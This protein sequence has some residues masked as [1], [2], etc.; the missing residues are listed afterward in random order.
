MED[1]TPTE[2]VFFTDQALSGRRIARA[3]AVSASCRAEIHADN[4]AVDALDETWLPEVGKR[5]WIVVTKDRKIQLRR[6]EIEA[7][8]SA[9]VRAFIFLDG[10]LPSDV[11]IA[12]I[13]LLMPK[14]VE[15]IRNYPPPFVFGIETPDRLVQLYPPVI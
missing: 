15:T 13:E 9:K 4:F 12:L 10:Q 5:E 3:L 8:T 7:L 6:N 2:L 1:Y 14:M 11:M